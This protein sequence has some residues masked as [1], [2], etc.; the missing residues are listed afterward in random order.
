MEDSESAHV[1]NLGHNTVEVESEEAIAK[2]GVMFGF[3]DTEFVGFGQ[4]LVWY[5]VR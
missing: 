3:E 5:Y 4:G 2:D 1:P